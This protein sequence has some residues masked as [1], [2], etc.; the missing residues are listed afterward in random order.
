MAVIPIG[1]IDPVLQFLDG[2]GKPYAAGSVTFYISGTMTLKNVFSDVGL[3]VILPNP[4]P[5]N[6]AGRSSTSTTG[7]VTPVYFSAAPYDY[8]LK[9]ANGLTVYGPEEFTGGSVTGTNWLTSTPQT[10]N[11]SAVAGDLVNATANSFNV[12]IPVAASNVSATIGIVNS[13]TGIITLVRSGS[14][15]IGLATSQTLKN[16][17]TSA[18]QG[19]AM[20]LNSDGVSN[21]T[22]VSQV[23]GLF[24]CSA[25]NSTT[26]SVNDSAQTALTFDTEDYDVG[27]MHSTSVNTSRMTIPTGGTGLY[28]V[29][30]NTSYA[31]NAGSDRLITIYKNGSAWRKGPMFTPFNG[32]SAQ[33]GLGVTA[34]MQLSAADYI[35][36]FVFQGTG[37]ALN[38]GS[39]TY[40]DASQ[41]Q[42]TQI[43]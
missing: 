14:D 32:T 27:A 43:A 26:Q 29:T 33:T 13:G 38:F 41:L 22:I 4:L 37:G 2:N 24:R 25:Y 15:T 34:F 1:M 35:E 17:G 36:I 3:S 40:S 7:P 9:D 20:I 30:A 31:A 10:A 5:L 16:S 23:K 8:V 6:A 39:A 11:Y 28:L 18:V 19:D 12:T 42:I 21:W